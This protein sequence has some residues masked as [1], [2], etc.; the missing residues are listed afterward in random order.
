VTSFKIPKSFEIPKSVAAPL[1]LAAAVLS[2]LI[3]LFGLADQAASLRSERDAKV[4]LL[5]RLAERTSRLGAASGIGPPNRDLVAASETLA[6]ASLDARL[7]QL[8]QAHTLNVIET[9]PEP[10]READGSKVDR[11]SVHAVVQ[12]RIAQVQG[13]LYALET[14]QPRSLIDNVELTTAAADSS[15]SADPQIHAAFTAS[16]RWRTP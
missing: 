15:A 16:A 8:A 10:E 2:A 7:R 5:G 6:A 1:V 3:G 11:V 9:R 13:L 12:G 14:E 4:D